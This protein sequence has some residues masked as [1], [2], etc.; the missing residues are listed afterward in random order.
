M[1]KRLRRADTEDLLSK[2]CMQR[3]MTSLVD[4]QLA[5]A[6]THFEKNTENWV[7]MWLDPDHI[8]KSECGAIA[9]HRGITVQ[10]D[11]LWLVRHK[12]KK[13]GY[14]SAASDPIV[15]IEEAA[16][17]WVE[18]R[19]IKR[20]WH[21]VEILAKAARKG[22]YRQTVY[23]EDA[24]NS[25]LCETGVRAFMTRVGLRAIR[26]PAWAVFRQQM[27]RVSCCWNLR[28]VLS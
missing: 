8:V 22:K 28:W 10:G 13:M 2:L 27:S 15:A 6:T 25:P 1:L 17:A 18:R 12:E 4:R 26:N 3:K 14:H 16:F 24:Y 9:A 20:R 21:E 23:I 11:L 5:V 19:R 7:H